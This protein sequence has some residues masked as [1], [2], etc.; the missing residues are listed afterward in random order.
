MAPRIRDRLTRAT[1]VLLP[2]HRSPDG[3]SAGSALAMR[4]ILER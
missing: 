4:I 2:L 3:D 1:L